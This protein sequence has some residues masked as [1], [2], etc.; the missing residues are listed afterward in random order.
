[1]SAIPLGVINDARRRQ[2]RLR[3]LVAIVGVVFVVA[4]FGALG[5]ASL[6]VGATQPRSALVHRPRER[7]GIGCASRRALIGKRVMTPNL[8]PCAIPIGGRDDPLPVTR[9]SP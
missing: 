7:A 4:G 2:T 5:K 3:L 9:S 6:F 8:M 1:M